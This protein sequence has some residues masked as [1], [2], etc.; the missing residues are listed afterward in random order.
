MQGRGHLM[1]TEGSCFMVST[2]LDALLPQ[3]T[4]LAARVLMVPVETMMTAMIR[5][6]T[7]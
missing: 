5:W 7:T 1:L 4:H 2:T 6:N 3:L